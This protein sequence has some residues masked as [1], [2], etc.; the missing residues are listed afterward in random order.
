MGLLKRPFGFSEDLEFPKKEELECCIPGVPPWYPRTT[1]VFFHEKWGFH[2]ANCWC[3]RRP[4][5]KKC[6]GLA[7]SKVQFSVKSHWNILKTIG[8]PLKY[9]EI[10]RLSWWPGEFWIN[11]SPLGVLYVWL[12]PAQPA[13]VGAEVLDLLLRSE[14]VSRKRFSW[15]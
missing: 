3:T 8:W 13:P 9:V 2:I 7:T 10:Q 12:V 4:A 15:E 14:S 5:S 11:P 6:G 1:G